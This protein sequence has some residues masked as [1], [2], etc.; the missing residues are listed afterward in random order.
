MIALVSVLA[1]RA[2][3]A[4]FTV[5]EFEQWRQYDGRRIRVIEFPGIHSFSRADLLTIMATEKPTWLRRYVPIGRRPI[6]YADDFAGDIMRLERFYSR[7][8]FPDATVRGHV[9]PGE[10]DMRLKFE[11]TEG[12][13]VILT[14]WR[15]TFVSDTGAAFD[16]ARWA[17]LMPIK[18]GKRLALSDVQ[19]SADTLCYKMQTIGH[20]RAR[21]DYNI[22]RD[23][24]NNY[25]AQ[26]TFMLHPGH[27]NYFGQ[28]R[29][30]GLKQIE[31]ETLRRELSYEEMDP[32]DIRELEKTRKRIVKLETFS[33][34]SVRADTGVSGDV[35]PVPIRTE[36]GNRYRMRAGAGYH[37]EDRARAQFEF[38]DLNFLGRGRRL[39][40]SV[41]YA[42]FRKNTEIR[43]FWPHTPLNWTDLTLA[44]K[45]EWLSDPAFHL[46][47]RST[48]TTLSAI[49][50]EYVTTAVSN[51][52]GLSILDSLQEG[53][54]PTRY[55]TSV[56]E[57]TV[58]WD[59][60]E[61]PLVARRG[62]FLGATLSESGAF[63]GARY[64]WWKT[65]WQARVWIPQGRLWTLAGKTEFDFM[66][67]L[68]QSRQTPIEERFKL[69]GP[70]LRGWSPRSPLAPRAISDTSSVI[71]G[72][73]V[74]F[75]A[76]A[77]VRRNIWGPASLAVFLDAG[78][79]W[80]RP[81]R[82][83]LFNLYPSAGAGL[84]L[85]TLVGP[86]RVDFGYQLRPN[87]YGDK[88]WAIH[89]SLGSPF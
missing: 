70:T 42:E 86:V 43:L 67:P 23:T 74:A 35:L 85:V 4:M 48:K 38:T 18:I 49:P 36:E 68:H 54:E 62:H 47:T 20:G 61:H 52:V 30:T 64:R 89:I 15:G 76:T 19:I 72:G 71:I 59:R 10:K 81:Y 65:I 32:F 8:G 44:P 56:E 29:V 31:E 33:L 27:F 12:R 69:A 83:K 51:E 80:S 7:E 24:I 63:Y 5:E 87:P 82:V 2:A 60:R 73:D 55:T 3:L 66:G 53:T 40:W 1:A 79:V 78:N 84:L 50:A 21:V 26:V 17:K 46:E 34:V 28:T 88:R 6:F 13:P 14:S 16:S 41:N 22:A 57:F 37:S 25:T 9:Y 75:S 58:G 11:I 39:T 77:E 45:W